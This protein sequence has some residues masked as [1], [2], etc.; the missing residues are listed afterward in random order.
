MAVV[1]V[2]ALVLLAG[3]HHVEER[4][5]HVGVLSGLDFITG[6]AESLKEEMTT[7]GYVEGEDIIYDVRYT[8]VEPEKERAILQG[9]V[10]DGVD[11]IVTFPTEVSMMA[12]SIASGTGI[13]VVFSFANIED[14]AL[15][16]SIKSPGGNITGVRYPG[17]DIAIKR[18]EVLEDLVPGAKRVWVPYQRGYPIVASQLAILRP[19]AE[20]ANVTLIEFPADDVDEVLSE[21]R[22]RNAS[23]DIGFDAV[24]MIVEPL[25]VTQQTHDAISSFGV[26][27]G[28]PVGGAIMPGDGHKVLFSVN[29]DIPAIGRQTAHVLDQVLQGAPAGTIPVI[30]AESFYDLDF[31]AAQRLGLNLSESSLASADHII[32]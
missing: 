1:L 28:L 29:V 16:E 9:F 31:V 27:H 2:L 32:R 30:S 15:V 26:E 14:T 21:L 3:C 12:K 8:N 7:L 25:S 10:D 13:P 17:P 22:R 19:A 11:A 18:F 24:L 6:I 4:T 23:D 20:E 5:Y